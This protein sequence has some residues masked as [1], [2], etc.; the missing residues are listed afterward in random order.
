MK[1]LNVKKLTLTTPFSGH[2][3]AFVYNDKLYLKYG[4]NIYHYETLTGTITQV[5]SA[6]L[7][8]C[9]VIN[10]IMYSL[11]ATSQSFYGVMT[12]YRING[13]DFTDKTQL[14]TKSI[15]MGSM[16]Y[17]GCDSDNIY[18]LRASSPSGSTTVYWYRYIYNITDGTFTEQS[19]GSGGIYS[20]NSDYMNI[21][22]R[23]II[24]GYSSPTQHDLRYKYC[25]N[26]NDSYNGNYHD[27]DN[28]FIGLDRN[29]NADIDNM[30]YIIG[31]RETI[32]NTATAY[33]KKISTFNITTKA[34]EYN[35]AELIENQEY[36]GCATYHNKIYCLAGQSAGVNTNIIQVLEFTDYDLTYTIKNSD[37][38]TLT[39]LEHL[40]PI[41]SMR[42]NTENSD[43]GVILNTLGGQ[44]TTTYTTIEPTGYKLVGYALT[45]NSKKVIIPVNKDI[46][47]RINESTTF[48]EVYARYTPVE[49]PIDIE[50]YVN[51]AELNRL[52]KTNYLTPVTTL[53]GVLRES[54]SII[55]PSIKI[56]LTTL[57]TFNYAYIQAFNRY[58]F[59]SNITSIRQGLWQIDL[60]V[61]V[62]MSYKD[63]I[64][65]NTAIINRTADTDYTNDLLNDTMQIAESI[66]TQEV[67]ELD[68]TSAEINFNVD[69]TGSRLAV[70]LVK[71]KGVIV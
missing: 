8:T 33:S 16:T 48:Y 29:N 38:A 66:P 41:E 1:V 24:T 67:I 49:T 21:C 39:T 23:Y 10:N 9:V 19:L 44:V 68:T 28:N 56:Y 65:L 32:G 7:G 60:R 11:E 45:P 47:I 46:T 61:D 34:I 6:T 64:I 50:L 55:T 63:S 2:C 14:A 53:H 69:S 5:A 27:S 36:F 12:I 31:G 22:S 71:A 57:P 70:S 59:V 26:N 17:N 54:T 40:A 3:D 4:N 52:D 30:I 51:S 42:I 13:T 18:F 20:Q 43:V 35:I 25:I 15:Y 58:Y 62:L 37:G